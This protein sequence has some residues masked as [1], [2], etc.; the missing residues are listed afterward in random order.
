[1][2][3]VLKT[4]TSKELTYEQKVLALAGLSENSLNVFNISDKT[5]FYLNEGALCN[6]FEGNAP[7][8][9]RYIM[10]DYEKY[11]KNGS[12]FLGVEPP[13][14]LDE[15]INALMI[16]YKHVPSITSFP[17]YLGNLDK[18]LDSFLDELTDDEIKKKFKLFLNFLDRTITDG[19]C[20]GNLGPEETRA[21]RLLL[22][23][24]QT[25]QNEVPN[26]T[27][28]YDPDITPDD[29]AELAIYTSLICANPA[30]A[31]HKVH[32]ETFEGDYGISSC[33]NILPIGGGS[34]T[35][36]RIV[37]TRL[38]KVAKSVDHFTD[39][40]LTEALESLGEYMN[41]RVR[42]LV[43]ESGFFESSFLVNEGLIELERFTAMFGITGLAEAVNTL[44]VDTSKKYGTDEEANELGEKIMNIIYDFVKKYPARYCDISGGH[45]MTHAQVGLEKDIGITS[46]VRIPVGDE[47]DNIIEHL[48]H[49][50]RFHKYI[51]TGC[52]DIFPMESTIKK[53]P[54]AA[55]DLVKGAFTLGVKYISFYEEDG[56]LVR[57]TGYLAKKSEMEKFRKGEQTIKN[58]TQLAAPNYD[59]NHL[60]DRKVRGANERST[61]K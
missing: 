4:I 50:S 34:F 42:F 11:I 45:F 19:F 10:P 38:V 32:K 16:I 7:Y 15:A 23:V 17:V 53:N 5:N 40:L 20:H 56:E 2:S 55:L 31:N 3:K 51:T 13:T 41:E 44:L 26:L 48:R 24:E 37:L 33:Y 25:L 12:E 43:E 14:D 57:I 54:T 27:L 52:G 49:S 30:I 35:L 22:E 59:V 1:M 58:T 6:L 47:P 21:G 61:H 29:F 39:E 18:L 9:P 28:K 46:G 60:E 8:R 36:S